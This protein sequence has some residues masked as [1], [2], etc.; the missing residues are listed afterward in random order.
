M[1]KKK[2][3]KA[4]YRMLPEVLV[5]ELRELSTLERPSKQLPI[6]ASE[7]N[8][9][10]QKHFSKIPFQNTKNQPFFFKL[11]IFFIFYFGSYVPSAPR[12]SPVAPEKNVKDTE[13]EVH[14]SNL[15]IF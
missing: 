3:E 14:F 5:R 4:I 9:K 1:N 10:T 7:S 13:N 15:Y 8:S 6:K 12:S 2:K 11:F